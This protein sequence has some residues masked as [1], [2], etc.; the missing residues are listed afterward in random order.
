M[1]LVLSANRHDAEHQP[2]CRLHGLGHHHHRPWLVGPARTLCLSRLLDHR[3]LLRL[4]A[5][6]L[7]WLQPRL[8]ALIV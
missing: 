1:E 4:R 7:P 8:W 6:E 3:R 2:S 5:P